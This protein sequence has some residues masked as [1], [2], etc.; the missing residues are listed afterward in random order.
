MA[1][2]LDS[3]SRH[4]V[5]LQKR[6]EAARAT[7]TDSDVKGSLNENLIAEFLR[8]IVPN[9]FVSVNS[10]I[11][12]SDDQTSDEIDICVCNEH[13]FYVQPS[14]GLLIAEGVDFV[15]QVKA[16]AT[17][18]EI[19]RIIK[20]C[21]SIKSL[22]RASDDGDTVFSPG[23]IPPEWFNYIPYI[24]FVFSSQLAEETI[25]KK[26][27]EQCSTVQ[28]EH[29]P[30]AVFVLDRGMTYINCRD[31]RGGTWQKNGK[32]HIG[33]LALKTDDATL[34]EMIRFISQRVL[35]FNRQKSPLN[36]YMPEGTR[37][38]SVG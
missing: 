33:W 34:F 10:Q 28:L 13:Q 21:I 29:Q 12:D 37:Y 11:M 2:I 14:G 17:S 15:I 5:V 18:D 35:K 9:W 22:K 30:D 36:H 27:N 31:G 6:F 32:P 20:N 16:V 24:C 26:L 3:I 23:H 38:P 1:K 4:S 19:V 7:V 8:D 25:L